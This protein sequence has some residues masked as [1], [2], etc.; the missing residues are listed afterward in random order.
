MTPGQPDLHRSSRPVVSRPEAP[1]VTEIDFDRL[2]RGRLERLQAAM[3]RHGMAVALLYNFANIRYATGTDLMAVWTG[4][5]LERYAVVPAEGTPVICEFRTGEHSAEKGIATVRTALSWQWAGSRAEDIAREWAA[6]IRDLMGELG[7]A[8]E[9]VAVDKLDATG[10]LA[11]ADAGLEVRDAWPACADARRVKTP[12]EVAL[13]RINGAV[14][15][16]MLHEFEAA[17]RPGVRELDLLAVLSSALL[18]HHGESLFT[19]LVA[20]GPNTNPW[21]QEATNRELQPGDL[22]GVDTDANGYEGYVIDVS[23]TFLCGDRATP[24]QKEAYRVAWDCVN[25]MIELARPGISFERFAR[26][27]PELPD[28]YKRLRYC[29]M[30]HPAG[31]EDESPGIPY[32]YEPGARAPDLELEENTVMCFECYAGKEGAGFGVKLE[33]QVLITRQG[34]ERLCL[35]P[36]DEK[37]L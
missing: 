25:G 26:E 37:L 19:R 30:A 35:F 15:D 21:L 29:S 12:E 1:V 36:Y 24:A 6:Q 34:C 20:S 13:F 23:R 18:R 3:R 11:L 22:V 33:D 32:L 4:S 17:I 31:L 28:A 8:G 7:V 10:F 16:A 2:R 5:T 14:G 27:A 9:P